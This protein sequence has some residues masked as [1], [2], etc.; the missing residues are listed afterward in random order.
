MNCGTYRFLS[1]QTGSGASLEL[2]NHL[3]RLKSFWVHNQL[4]FVFILFLGNAGCNT[5]CFDNDSGQQ[6]LA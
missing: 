2:N 5:S 3:I 1:L 6:Q 4:V